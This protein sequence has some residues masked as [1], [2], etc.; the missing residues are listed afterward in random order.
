MAEN[1]ENMLQFLDEAKNALTIWQES[2]AA[3][4]RLQAE[5][6][7]LERTLTQERT[8]LRT[9]VDQ[10]IRR[11]R[12]ELEKTYSKK[13]GKLASSR[14]KVSDDRSKAYQKRVKERAAAESADTR[15]QIQEA[16]RNLKD[17][18]QANGVPGFCR[19]SFFY[20]VFAP[21]SIGEILGCALF[22]LIFFG[23]LPCA[24]YYFLTPRTTLW[25]VLTFV[26]DVVLFGG[27]YIVIRRATVRKYK[28]TIEDGRRHRDFIRAS[29]KQVKKI[30]KGVRKES[31]ESQYD[32]GEFDQKLDSL[33]KDQEAMAGERNRAFE[34]FD[35][36]TRDEIASSILEGSR[37]R[38]SQMERELAEA[39][40]ELDREREKNAS[41]SREMDEK[42]VPVIGE[43]F[44]SQS[45][46][47]ELRAAVEGGAGSL[48]EA[49]QR[50]REKKAAAEP[51]K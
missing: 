27:L 36:K 9:R 5:A 25:L 37:E 19:S 20:A 23:V 29:K 44:L 34:E 16:R 10:E 26:I 3:S 7:R 24:V 2:G 22:F 11:K 17:L 31:E 51:D 15:R 30:E 18:F 32:L 35:K 48:N 45:G 1:R 38:L 4:D 46:L 39:R 47:E 12:A 13:E 33:S 6:T 49:I 40:E 28:E 50:V 42:Y 14:K 21:K 43:E 41:W 8:A